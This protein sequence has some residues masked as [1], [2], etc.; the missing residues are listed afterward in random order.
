MLPDFPEF[1]KRATAE[2]V[3]GIEL[4]IPHVAPLLAGIR[5]TRIHEGTRATLTRADASTDSMDFIKAG[6]EL[7]I[8]SEHMK[9]VTPGELVAH[10]TAIAEQLAEHQSRVLIETISRATE[11]T[12]NVVSASDLGM[13]AAFL[14]MERRIESDFDPDTL[15]RKGISLVV[16]P[17]QAEK[18]MALAAEWENDQDFQAELAAIRSQKLEEWRARERDRSLVD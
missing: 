9:H 8:P 18:L 10:I 1:K 16:H 11:S 6:A 15:Q 13:K 14:E 17:S 2:I 7:A 3:A 5:R 12:G 4:R